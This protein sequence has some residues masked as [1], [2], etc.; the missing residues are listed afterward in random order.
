[1]PSANPSLKKNNQERFVYLLIT[2][3]S[4]FLIHCGE[5]NRLFTTSIT[6]N[7]TFFQNFRV[8]PKKF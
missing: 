8:Q 6:F 3:I 7:G 5:S 2:Q 1:M 4:N